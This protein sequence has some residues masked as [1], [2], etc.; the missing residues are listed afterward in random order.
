MRQVTEPGGLVPAAPRMVPCGLQLSG[1][2]EAITVN[3]S[4]TVPEPE[5]LIPPPSPREAWLNVTGSPL[6]TM[7]AVL[8]I[9]PPWS[10]ALLWVIH[11]AADPGGAARVR[12]NGAAG[13]GSRGVP[14]QRRPVNDE[15]AVVENGAADPIGEVAVQLRAADS[16][17]RAGPDGQTAA[18][19]GKAG[20]AGEPDVPQRDGARVPDARG[21]LVGVHDF[22]VGHGEVHQGEPAPGGPLKDAEGGGGVGGAADRGAPAADDEDVPGDRGQAIV[23]VAAALP[24]S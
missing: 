12:V 13:P 10:F 20:V 7:V 24:S 17:M 18:E 1:E 23:L 22:P 15:V 3:C 11:G 6:S 16:G 4:T 5:L 8:K 21:P 14:G 2:L 9:P 19:V